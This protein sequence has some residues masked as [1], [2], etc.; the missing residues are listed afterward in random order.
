MA[1]GE[2]RLQNHRTNWVRHVTVED[3]IDEPT[4]DG[5]ATHIGVDIG[6]TALITGCAL[7]DGSPTA[8]V[9]C[10]GRSA[11][12]LRRERYTALKRLQTRDAAEWRLTER[13]AHY[14]NTLADI[15]EKA[16]RQAVTDATQFESPVVVMADLTD[17]RERLDYGTYRNRRLHSWAFARLHGRIEDKATEA[18]IPVECVTPA[19]TPQTCHWW[20]RI[21]RRDSQT[22]VRCPHDDCHVSTCRA[23]IAAAASIARRVDPWGERVPLDKAGRDDSPRDGSGRDTATTPTETASPSR[24]HERRAASLERHCETSED[25]SQLTLTADREPAPS[26]SDDEL[27]GSTCGTPC[28]SRQGRCHDG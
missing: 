3:P 13:C 21:G 17:I 1:A 7:R 18:G 22:D 25:A 5:D 6:E 27:V 4:T 11:T 23:D 16:S 20:H 19:Y 2:R 12:Q 9:V 24:G 14:Q 26:A 28:R 8:P 15:V 10:D